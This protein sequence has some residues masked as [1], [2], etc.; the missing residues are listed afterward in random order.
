MHF[1]FLDIILLVIGFGYVWGGWWT[2]LIQS[3]GGLVGLFVGEVVAGRTYEKF[4]TVMSPVFAGNQIVAKVFAFLLIFLLVAKLV[5]ALFWVVNK[6]FN[7][8]A[9]VP[10]M[11]FANHVGGAFFGLI[12]ASLFIGI[13]LQFLVRLPISASFASFVHNSFVATYALNITGWL[14]PLLPG[15]IKQA[16]D[17]TKNIPSINV[18]SAIKTYNT[19]QN[20]GVL[21][22]NIG[23]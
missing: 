17:A 12:E 10:G 11:K 9:I 14:V 1:N 7:I 18:N 20:S 6:M 19:I 3:I 23:R 22:S 15:V 16:E 2:G 8:I 13:G 21:N 4:A 5:G